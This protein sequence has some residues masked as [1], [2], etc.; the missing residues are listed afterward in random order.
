MFAVTADAQQQRNPIE[1]RLEARK[2]VTAA[3]GKES[4]GPPMPPARAT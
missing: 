4:F 1:S 2:V 3:N